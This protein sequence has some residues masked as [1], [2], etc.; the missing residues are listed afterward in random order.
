V[1][2]SHPIRRP[3]ARTTNFS[4]FWRHGDILYGMRACVIPTWC[5]RKYTL[6]AVSLSLI[7]MGAC[8]WLLPS[9][10][11]VTVPLPPTHLERGPDFVFSRDM[12]FVAFS[13]RDPPA[14]EH[15]GKTSIWDLHTGQLVSSF[16][17]EYID[18]RAFSN[19]GNQL[20]EFCQG[21]PNV[22][23]VA[24]GLIRTDMEVPPVRA[25]ATDSVRRSDA[26]AFRAENGRCI[27]W[28]TATGI[29]RKLAV[30]AAHTPA[31]SPDGRYLAVLVNR[32]DNSPPWLIWIRKW[33]NLSPS[34][35]AF[36]LYDLDAES[37]MASW[38]AEHP[39]FRCSWKAEF[40]PDGRS[41]ALISNHSVTIYDFPLCRPWLTIVGCGLL[42]FGI[43]WVI[44]QWLGWTGCGRGPRIL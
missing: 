33:L 23:D 13:T 24:T 28:H 43:I 35:K 21:K 22:R 16:A 27:I 36:V 17:G 44:S 30:S 31:L 1:A 41:M 12:R 34:G 14:N 32:S 26:I 7:T 38:S 42:T 20:I 25:D 2:S 37:A 4:H 15:K 40:S 8:W 29:S 11:R 19:D 6:I 18:S 10:A 3:L 39:A 9:P 5:R